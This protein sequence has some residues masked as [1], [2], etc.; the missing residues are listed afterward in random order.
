MSDV[1]IPGKNSLGFRRLFRSSDKWWLHPSLSPALWI[2]RL[3]AHLKW[4]ARHSELRVVHIVRRDNLAWLMSKALS[5]ETGRYFGDSYPEDARASICV[6]SAIKRLA[7][8]HWVDARLK[9]LEWTNPYLRVVYEDFRADNRAYAE[10]VVEFLGHDPN[11]LP[12]LV[13]QAKPQ[14][15]HDGGAV[16]TNAE[17]LRRALQAHDMLIAPG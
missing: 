12:P 15:R 17:A 13:M 14:S 16:V 6:Q 8:K 2:D 11:A 7:A 4:L 9:T 5:S 1:F 10:R 3:E